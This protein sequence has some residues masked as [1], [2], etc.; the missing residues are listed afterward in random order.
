MER[1]RGGRECGWKANYRCTESMAR[2]RELGGRESG[3]KAGPTD[4]ATECCKDMAATPGPNGC[5]G[6]NGDALLQASAGRALARR[7]ARCARAGERR[8][9]EQEMEE[10]G[11]KPRLR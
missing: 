5:D 4:G 2:L 8:A 6:F 9:G 3:W 1:G 10:R 11:L 7:V